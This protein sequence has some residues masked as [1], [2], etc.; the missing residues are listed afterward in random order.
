MISYEWT[1]VLS[2]AVYPLSQS[3]LLLVLALLLSL[4]HR[5][6]T[7]QAFLLLAV[8]WLYLCSTALFAD[9]LMATLEDDFPPRAMSVVAPAEAIVVLGGAISGDS[10]L[11][12]QPNLNQA[13]DRLIHAARLYQAGKAPLVVASGGG[14]PG[15]RPEAQLMQETMALMGVPQEAMLLE[16]ASRNTHDNARFTAVLLHGKGI[17][18]ILLVTSAFHMRRARD[19]FVA[20][21]FEVVPAPTDYQRLASTPTISR[22]LPITDDLLR[23]TLALKEHV[24]FWVYRYRGWL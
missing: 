8:S 17:R 12:T 15:F 1:K 24:G 13:A 18:K 5:T 9:F 23:S 7:A 4:L 6:H 11:G 14:Q 16:R 3:L 2:L 20:E 19:L 22:W 10:H 21:G